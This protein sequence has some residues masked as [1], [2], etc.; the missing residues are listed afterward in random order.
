[1]TISCLHTDRTQRLREAV[2]VETSKRM[3]VEGELSVVRQRVFE[4]LCRSHALTHNLIR[5]TVCRGG[6]GVA[7]RGCGN[8]AREGAA[9]PEGEVDPP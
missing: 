8:E 6:E 2:K 4:Q 9:A 3:T 5:C 1:M 7:V